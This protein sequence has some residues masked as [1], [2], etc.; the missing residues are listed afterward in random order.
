MRIAIDCHNLEG[1]RTGV[2]RYLWNVLRE[3]YKLTGSDPVSLELFLYFK[4]EIPKDLDAMDRPYMERRESHIRVLDAGS[5][6]VYKHLRLPLAVFRDKADV[7]FCPDYVLPILKFKKCKTAVT[8]H[9][10]IYEARPAEY[11][12]PSFADKILLKWASKR[13]AKKADVI[14]F[15]SN[16]TKSEIEK[17][18]KINS[19]KIT[20]TRLA[21][22]PIFRK[23]DFSKIRE[24]GYAEKWSGIKKKYRIGD[25]FVFFVGSIFNRRFLPKTVDAFKEFARER[26]DF[27]FLIIGKNHSSPYQDI[28]AVI[29]NTNSE[30]GREAVVWHEF[31]R[32]DDDLVFLYN[33]ALATVWVSSYE[34]FGLPILESMACGTPV[35]TSR[36]SSLEE[37]GGDSA[38]YIK[39]P[40][41]I[42]EISMA[43]S[44]LSNDNNYR[45]DLSR[46]CLEYT[47]KFSWQN[48]AMATLDCLLR[49]K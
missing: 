32:N 47:R 28:G 27:Q 48:T 40:G 36:G 38:I 21:P 20:V 17:Y 5:N 11:S 33:K 39:D 30:M 7:L 35:I 19:K 46:K 23:P 2:G 18:Y 13:S 26:D 44:K 14:F 4:N 29:K 9:D 49:L 8:I 41:N 10:I 24:I 6:A 15:P 34:G 1:N 31:I 12:W 16:F 45:L 37:V 25:N 43:L 42:R 3:W 22:D